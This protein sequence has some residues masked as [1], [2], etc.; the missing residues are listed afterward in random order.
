M[1]FWSFL[2][3]YLHIVW[4]E[5]EK[6]IPQVVFHMYH[7]LSQVCIICRHDFLSLMSVMQKIMSCVCKSVPSLDYGHHHVAM[8]QNQNT[9]WP[10]EFWRKLL[11][12][13]TTSA[14]NHCTIEPSQCLEGLES[15]SWSWILNLLQHHEWN[16]E[17][18]SFF[19]KTKF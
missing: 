2:S 8:N 5:I 12:P 10:T 16:C 14:M 13:H 18:L 1:A 3:K 19:L 15:W 9:N 17:T 11:F 4:D 6:P 7:N